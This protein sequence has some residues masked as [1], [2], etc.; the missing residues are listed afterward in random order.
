MPQ[1]AINLEG[2]RQEK[3]SYLHQEEP[4]MAGHAV[5]VG[6]DEMSSIAEEIVE[7]VISENER[8]GIRYDTAQGY[9]DD[10]IPYRSDEHESDMENGEK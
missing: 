5:N 4:R 1:D 9:L 8:N 2:N 10:T 6:G 3:E 7:E